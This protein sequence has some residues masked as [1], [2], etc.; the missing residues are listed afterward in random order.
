M[1]R[2]LAI[3]ILAPTLL[4]AG[5]KE[6]IASVNGVSNGA[7]DYYCTGSDGTRHELG[8]VVCLINNSC[9]QTWLAKCDMSLNNPM[10]RKVQD[11][12]PAATLFQRFQRLHPG[13][14]T[15]SINTIVVQAKT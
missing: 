2:L 12:C 1:L 14:N 11:G 10:W 9:S 7:Y 4:Q 13:L 5:A 6:D 15:L 3:L 8:E